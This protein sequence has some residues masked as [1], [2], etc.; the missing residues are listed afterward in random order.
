MVKYHVSSLNQSIARTNTEINYFLIVLFA[1]ELQFKVNDA[2][3]QDTKRICIYGKE[4][5]ETYYKS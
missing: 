3:E 1:F 5:S 2:M 4:R